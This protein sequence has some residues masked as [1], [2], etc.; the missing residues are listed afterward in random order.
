MLLGMCWPVQMQS[1]HV[2]FPVDGQPLRG[3]HFRLATE[4]GI[5]LWNTK[6]LEGGYEGYD[7]KTYGGEALVQIQH[8]FQ[9]G[10]THIHPLISL[11]WFHKNN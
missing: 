6:R 2:G 8:S 3:N 11:Y 1:E 7:N 4:G 10:I 9:V 5:L